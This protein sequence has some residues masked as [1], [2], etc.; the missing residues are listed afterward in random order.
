MADARVKEGEGPVL[1]FS[2][3]LSRAA[4]GALAVDYAKSDGANA[5][6]MS[7]AMTGFCP[8]LGY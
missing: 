1:A 6:R 7:T 2:V 4:S 5:G 8:W 3:T